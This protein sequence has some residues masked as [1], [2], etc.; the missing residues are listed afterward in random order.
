M[1]R[2]RPWLFVAVVLFALGV[3]GV[4]VY[5]YFDGT[6][7][8]RKARTT[9]F[10]I[11]AHQEKVYQRLDALENYRRIPLALRPKLVIAGITVRPT[12]ELRKNLRD[13]YGNKRLPSY[14]PQAS[15]PEDQR[16]WPKALRNRGRESF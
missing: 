4:A 12:K 16:K 11:Y 9:A 8:S 1:T 6:T 13:R 7:D 14:C 5:L 2:H 10:C 3:S 15:W